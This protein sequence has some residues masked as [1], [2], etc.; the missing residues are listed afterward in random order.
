MGDYVRFWVHCHLARANLHSLGVLYHQEF[1][2]VD[3]EMVYDTLREV[4]WLFQVWACKQVMGIA[5]T[6]EWD[7]SVVRFCPSCTVERDTCT[8]VLFCCHEG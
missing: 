4:P 5:G 6:M 1:N 3:W 8:H 7:K 2:Y